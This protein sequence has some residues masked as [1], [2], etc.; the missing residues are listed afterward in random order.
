ML[1]TLDKEL[2]ADCNFSASKMFA[3][4]FLGSERTPNHRN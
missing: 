1:F 4:I 3:G 2:M